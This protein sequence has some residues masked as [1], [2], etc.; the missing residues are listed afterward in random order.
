MSA[1]SRRTPDRLWAVEM[2]TAERG[3]PAGRW[4]AAEMYESKA[5]ALREAR[6]SRDLSVVG[7]R[8]RVSEWR[9]VSPRTPE[10]TR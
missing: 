7:A 1:P 2:L 8:Y 4:L 10:P 6:R 3:V 9:R 5:E